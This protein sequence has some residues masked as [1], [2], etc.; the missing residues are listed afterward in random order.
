MLLR[1]E[2][3]FDKRTHSSYV[4]MFT[5]S[6]VEKSVQLRATHWEQNSLSSIFVAHFGK[7]QATIGTFSIM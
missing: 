2:S 7:A 4:C 3:K 6:T 1:V 5:L